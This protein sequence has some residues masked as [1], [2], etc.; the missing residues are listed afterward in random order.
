[1]NIKSYED[2]P[3]VA[4]KIIDN[5]WKQNKNIFEYIDRKEMVDQIFN[6]MIEELTDKIED[7]KEP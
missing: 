4:G 2:I 5:I 1:M 7:W 3:I 6:F